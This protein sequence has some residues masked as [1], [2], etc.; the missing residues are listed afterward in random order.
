MILETNAKLNSLQNSIQIDLKDIR[1][2]NSQLGRNQKN[3]GNYV[4]GMDV[5]LNSIQS[6]LSNIKVINGKLD[7]IENSLET[8]KRTMTA[9]LQVIQKNLGSIQEMNEK[10]DSN[11]KSLDNYVKSIVNGKLDSIQKNL[12]DYMKSING[13]L[14]IIQKNQDINKKAIDR[15]L[16][17]VQDSVKDLKGRIQGHFKDLDDNMNRNLE[18]V[19]H[20][21]QEA[22][23]VQKKQLAINQLKTEFSKYERIIEDSLR[24]SILYRKTN[25]T[26]SRTAFLKFGSQLESAIDAILDGLLGG[27]IF[28]SDILIAIR[29]GK[30]VR[31]LKKKKDYSNVIVRK[32]IIN[33]IESSNG[34]HS[35]LSRHQGSSGSRCWCPGHLLQNI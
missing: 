4:T 16:N 20:D 18:S 28:G 32:D 26:T 5:K 31:T 15:Q 24:Y 29:T 25:S 34:I 2:M 27:G 23:E 7:N 22:F 11:Q 8:N 21:L 12:G 35:S 9:Q 3:L 33:I 30:N 17:G 13:K 10:L 6:S 14:E 1:D 19:K